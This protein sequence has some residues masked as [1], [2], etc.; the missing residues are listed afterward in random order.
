MLFRGFSGVFKPVPKTMQLSL[1]N[2]LLKIPGLV[3]VEFLK[4]FMQG[5]TSKIVQKTAK[6]CKKNLKILFFQDLGHSE[7]TF[8]YT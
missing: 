7:E 8:D 1:Q 5:S 3:I 6:K 4:H 2:C